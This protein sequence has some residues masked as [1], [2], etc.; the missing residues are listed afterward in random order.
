M[1]SLNYW[2]PYQSIILV[3]VELD[4]SVKTSVKYDVFSNRSVPWARSVADCLQECLVAPDRDSPWCGPVPLVT[5][6]TSH[7]PPQGPQSP[8][9]PGVSVHLW[10][11]DLPCLHIHCSS[12]SIWVKEGFLMNYFSTMWRGEGGILPLIRYFSKWL[13]SRTAGSLGYW[14]KISTE[15]AAG[16]LAVLLARPSYSSSAWRPP[17][18]W[19]WCCWCQVSQL[20]LLPMTTERSLDGGRYA[21]EPTRVCLIM[22]VF[23][24]G[25]W[26]HHTADTQVRSEVDRQIFHFSSTEIFCFESQERSHNKRTLR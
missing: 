12:W 15:T 18:G 26:L 6:Q 20:H 11:L 2:Q 10:Q 3:N 21:P 4:H 5:T 22:L 25:I 24:L 17:S 8:L 9:L 23:I 19:T 13:K 16:R 1:F 7:Q 14:R